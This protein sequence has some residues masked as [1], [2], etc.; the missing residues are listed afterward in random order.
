MLNSEGHFNMAGPFLLGD[1]L[2]TYPTF[3]M[4]MAAGCRQNSC[5]NIAHIFA[6]F[7]H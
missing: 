4:L 3:D 7:N 2:I 1:T 6:F 5:S